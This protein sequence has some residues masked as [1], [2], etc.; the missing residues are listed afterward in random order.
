MKSKL[1]NFSVCLKNLLSFLVCWWWVRCGWFSWSFSE[2][3]LFNNYCGKLCG[4]SV[5]NIQYIRNWNTTGQ[6]NFNEPFRIFMFELFVH[7]RCMHSSECNIKSG[8]CSRIRK[9]LTRVRSNAMKNVLKPKR[10]WLRKLLKIR[11]K[12]ASF[13]STTFLNPHR[14]YFITNMPWIKKK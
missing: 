4:K 10:I 13:P 5:C 3:F 8:N 6:W 11:Q 12:S 9:T 2:V 14:I 7:I 1:P